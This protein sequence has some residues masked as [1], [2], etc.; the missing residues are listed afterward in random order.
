MH[1]ENELERLRRI[2][3]PDILRHLAATPDPRDPH[4]WHTAEGTL[5]ITGQ[6]FH[7]WSRGGG[8]GGAIDLLIHLL[9]L[10]FKSAIA[11]L[12]NLAPS[13]SPPGTARPTKSP[14]APPVSDPAHLPR[15]RDYLIARRKLPPYLT[16]HLIHKG[17]LYPD[18][19]ANAVFLMRTPTHQTVGAEL[20]GTSLRR[21]WR[22][23]APASRKK[24]AYFSIRLDPHPT[25]ILLCESAIDAISCLHIH[26]GT[27]CLSSAG[28][29][30]SPP[31]LPTLLACN[32]P[33]YCAYDADAPGEQAA[34][35][36]ILRY[37][38]IQRLRPTHK[39]WND[40][41]RAQS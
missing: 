9:H 10:D 37:P 1:S 35:Q 25:A 11:H 36:M 22:G 18:R 31:W 16:D 30:A 24:E 38:A 29:P 2:P 32:L 3:L 4:R 40:Q 19:F 14:F 20:H 26:P 27:A 17:T 41:L 34:Q 5:S 21:T 12:H 33:T 28:C 8:G 6:K 15:V 13:Q 39:D 23:L 7:N